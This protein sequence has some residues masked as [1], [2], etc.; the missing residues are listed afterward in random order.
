MIKAAVRKDAGLA[1]AVA[2]E[3]RKRWQ[4]GG[5]EGAPPLLLSAAAAAA[6]LALLFVVLML[7]DPALPSVSASRAGAGGTIDA[8]EHIGTF[9]G[10]ERPVAVAT[11][12]GGNV[13]VI[14]SA[15]R[16]LEVFDRRGA[17]VRTV[18]ATAADSASVA[19]DEPWRVVS[20]TS[21][22]G[23][24]VDGA[25]R[26]YVS[27][28]AQRS[29]TVLDPEGRSLGL[30]A[31]AAFADPAAKPGVLFQ[32]DGRLYVCDLGRHRVLVFDLRG[33][34]LATVGTGGGSAPGALW[35]PNGVWADAAGTI[36]VA[37]TNNNRIQ[38]FAPDG[39]LLR[40]IETPLNNPRGLVGDDR[41][42]LYV[43]STMDHR[44]VVLGQDGRL[45][46]VLTAASGQGL[47]FPTGLAID[48]DRLIATD[49]AAGGVQLWRLEP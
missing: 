30:F 28:V 44:V 34:L 46:G 29:I 45:L 49:R 5:A 3:I 33:E 21:P 17:L 35:Y 36:Y 40:V 47:G 25:G 37:D 15:R 4:W 19:V 18:G 22:L 38:Q 9:A 39:A 8:L 11:G 1:R 13:Y 24:A 26:V 16:V 43:A 41:G 27:D 20:F 32:R 2:T 6:V 7:R 42:R 12:A 10:M 23:V 14:D 31:A 48:G